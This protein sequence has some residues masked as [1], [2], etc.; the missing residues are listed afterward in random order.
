MVASPVWAALMVAIALVA[1]C[2]GVDARDEVATITRARA[3]V[4]TSLGGVEGTVVDE[5]IQPITEAS[6]TLLE[7]GDA[8]RTRDDGS[9]AFSLVRPGTYTLVVNATGFVPASGTVQVRAGS[10]AVY[11]LVLAQLASTEAYS[12]VLELAGFFEC[13]VEVGWNVSLIPEPWNDL[14]AG[15]AACAL[16]NS[17]V[18]G[19]TTNDRFLHTFELEAPL[20]TLVYEM[21]W[22]PATQFSQWMTTRMEVYGFENDEVGTVFRVQGPSPIRLDL[23]RSA[24]RQL[25]EDFRNGCRDGHDRFCDHAFWDE[26]WDLQTRVFPAWQCA[27]EAGGGCVALQQDFTHYV[28]AFYN[29][30]APDGYSATG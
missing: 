3:D 28:S 25:D 5:A 27:S 20:D 10:V 11:D 26:G 23:D 17:Y 14:Y 4:S 29:A 30:P 13:G 18:Q 24:W 15:L 21:V 2:V 19:N 7:T 9:F 8:L 22:D 6:V 16:P 1:G 12:Q